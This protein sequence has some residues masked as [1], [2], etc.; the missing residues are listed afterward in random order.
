MVGTAPEQFFIRIAHGFGFAATQQD[1]E[2]H[3]LE[4]VILIAMDNARRARDAIPSA[5]AR[6]D[7]LAGF[8]LHEHIEESLQHEEA[9]FD[10]VG[11]GRVALAGMHEHDREG[12]IAGRNDRRITMFAGAAGTDEAMLRP[13]VALDLGVLE[14]GPVGLAVAESAHIAF[15]DLFNRNPDQFLGKRMP[16][17]A[18]RRTPVDGECACGR[19]LWSSGCL[20]QRTPPCFAE[21]LHLARRLLPS[22][23]LRPSHLDLSPLARRRK[24]YRRL[25][26]P[27][28]TISQTRCGV[29][30]SSRGST[31]NA[32]S[33]FATAFATMPPAG[34]MPPSPAPLAP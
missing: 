14:G 30:G 7:A 17:D 27:A 11:V 16:C 22:P 2:V 28:S 12:E 20:R 15:H 33:A 26:R 9:F 8:I 18:H 31:P 29:S 10:L 34:M 6:G 23:G 32:R 4:A 21:Q 19:Y 25:L 13:L 1:L 3:G 24:G 5:E